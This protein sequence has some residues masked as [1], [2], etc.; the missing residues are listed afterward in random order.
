MAFVVC[1]IDYVGDNNDSRVSNIAD[2]MVVSNG[3][4]TDLKTSNDNPNEIVNI[5]KNKVTEFVK[6]K[7]Q[8]D[9]IFSSLPNNANTESCPIVPLAKID[10]TVNNGIFCQYICEEGQ[11]EYNYT[12]IGEFLGGIDVYQASAAGWFY[13]AQVTRLH[14]FVYFDCNYYCKLPQGAT[15][16]AKGSTRGIAK[17][18]MLR[19]GATGGIAKGAVL[20]QGAIA[21]PLVAVAQQ[22]VNKS[23]IAHEVIPEA[24]IVP[25]ELICK[26]YCEG[27][28][29]FP[30]LPPI[31][32]D[33][34]IWEMT[35]EE[36]KSF[37][38]MEEFKL[39][40][41]RDEST[42]NYTEKL[43]NSAD[44]LVEEL[45]QF[46]PCKLTDKSSAEKRER[47]RIERLGKHRS[48]SEN[49]FD[50][51]KSIAKK[52]RFVIS[53]N[54]DGSINIDNEITDNETTDNEIELTQVD[55]TQIENSREAAETNQV[56]IDIYGD[57][58][59]QINFADEYGKP[60]MSWIDFLMDES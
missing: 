22:I 51:I 29:K 35:D 40:A 41:F 28:F 1:R 39:V 16:I 60:G 31:Q 56:I 24:P 5:L 3:E 34:F 47:D 26:D 27:K 44:K 18:A 19:Q 6:N 49:D 50:R 13:N 21:T 43:T 15:I 36:M 10:T 30:P 23:P 48:Q 37:L 38:Q 55:M 58:T 12:P 9:D 14:S 11:R 32:P 53:N 33:Q 42:T 54:L 17:G 57:N 8:I 25:K 2:M 4:A 52:R 45:K 7:Y 46:N 20:R 59:E